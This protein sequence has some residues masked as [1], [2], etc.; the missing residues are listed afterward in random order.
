MQAF[1]TLLVDINPR[2]PAAAN[3]STSIIRCTVSAILIA[4]LDNIF[5]A[6]G[7]GFAFMI[8]GSF[9]IAVLVL[10]VIEYHK[11]MGW[12]QNSLDNTDGMRRAMSQQ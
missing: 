12:R 11:G 8:I 7:T 10:F 4:F 5:D 9:C 6:V 1:N 3:A 2:S